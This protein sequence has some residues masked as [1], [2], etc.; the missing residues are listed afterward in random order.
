VK[1]FL[2]LRYTGRESRGSAA[3]LTFFV[4]CLAVGVA[5]VVSV[6][7]FASGVDEGIQ[8]KARELLAADIAVGGMRPIPAE[9]DGVVE[10][11]PGSE[12]SDVRELVTLVVAGS[13]PS[14]GSSRLSRLKVVQ[15]DYPFYGSLET[16]PQ[17]PLRELLDGDKEAVVADSLLAQLGLEPGGLLMIGGKIFTVSAS[18]R[19]EPDRLDISFATLL[20]R[21]F[22]SP[23]GLDRAG[24]ER[25]GSRVF[26]R[27]LIKLPPGSG[28]GDVRSA[29]TTI[30]ESLPDI[31]YLSVETYAEAQPALREALRRAERFLGLVA[32][33][34]LLIGGI[35]VGQTVRAWLAGRMETIAILKCLGVRPREV[36]TLYLGQTLLLGFVGSVAGALLGTV[37]LAVVPGFF[38][39]LMPVDL[40]RIWQ[41]LALMRGVLMGVGVAALFSLAPLLSVLRVPPMRALRQDAE[42]LKSSPVT[43]GAVA[44]ALVTGVFITAFVQ[45]GSLGLAFWFTLGLLLMVGLLCA[46]AILMSR[47]VSRL[48]RERG[49]VWLRHGLAALGRPGAGTVGAI[50]ALGL[51]VVVV[52]GMYLIERRLSAQFEADLPEDAPSAFLINIQP[53]QW[54]EIREQLDEEGATQIDSVPVINARI[55][56]VDGVPV[57]DLLEEESDRRRRRWSLTREQRLTYMEDLPEDNEIVEGDL[58]SD[59]DLPEV[60]IERDFAADLGAGVGSSLI[61]D[62]HGVPLELAVT[63]IR[64]VVWERFGIN[65]FLIVEPGVLDEVPQSRVAAVR[66]PHD[67][68][69]GI[70]DRLARRFPNLT[71]IPIRAFL[72]RVVSVLRQAGMGVKI[73]GSLTVVAGIFILGGAIS[74]G[75]VR[76]GREV[77]LMK[78][79]GMTRRGVAAVY[80]VEYALVGGAA[81]VMGV[82]G[83]GILAWAILKWWMEVT[84]DFGGIPFVVAAGAMILLAVVA[85]TVVSFR[86]LTRRPVEVLRNE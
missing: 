86:A 16:T 25:F 3:R 54:E 44:A 64:T 47:G 35:G 30:R 11:L 58:W 40:I 10:S 75:S 20:P 79:L 48:P 36:L 67:A 76:R 15:G 43:R 85:G 73:L 66:L 39:E 19:K 33:L 49:R 80:S 13:G 51:G 38:A 24:L 28:A 77:A 23:A 17:R 81:G 31:D 14:M 34:S 82:A 83:A 61:L 8:S 46:V 72:D 68:E 70:Q 71:M 26:H 41:P 22:L 74:A 42:P 4:I 65:F 63:S 56:S 57:S 62:L 6:A 59:P 69:Q 45:S 9:L 32:L 78:T 27:A 12:R 84:P 37:A 60:S 7:G 2:Y 52:L 18:L 55:L 53:D 29:A 50:V 5:A 1:A 21:I